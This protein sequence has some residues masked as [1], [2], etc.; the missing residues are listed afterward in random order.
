MLLVNIYELARR[1]SS[2]GYL[3]TRAA[4]L[5]SPA[6][7]SNKIPARNTLIPRTQPRVRPSLPPLT[8][9]RDSPLS[10]QYIPARGQCP[11]SSPSHSTMPLSI[12]RQTS[13]TSQPRCS[14]K[15]FP[16]QP[17]PWHRYHPWKAL[18]A[19]SF[20]NRWKPP[21]TT[22][23]PPWPPSSRTAPENLQ[24]SAQWTGRRSIQHSYPH[25]PQ[26]IK[27]SQKCGDPIYSPAVALIPSSH[28]LPWLYGLHVQGQHVVMHPITVRSS[29]EPSKAKP[30]PPFLQALVMS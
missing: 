23:T 19:G 15:E 12:C 27:L 17:P 1:P 30:R 26:T 6:E 13:Q 24:A 3:M 11:T 9:T 16:A 28:T 4:G 10:D 14:S 2:R 18:H 29:S 20:F 8:T 22:E 7:T 5:S 21:Q 25:P